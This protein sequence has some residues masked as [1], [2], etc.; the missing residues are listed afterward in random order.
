MFIGIVLEHS[1]HIFPSVLISLRLVPTRAGG[2]AVSPGR[3]RE[4]G[5]REAR[6]ERRAAD[7]SPGG[8]GRY[9]P[10]LA[11]VGS[12]RGGDREAGAGR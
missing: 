6:R 7:P 11:R 5:G 10:A 9:R 3:G 8:S 4:R 1:F 12:D 2:G